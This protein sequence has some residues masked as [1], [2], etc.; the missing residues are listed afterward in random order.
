MRLQRLTLPLAVSG[1][2]AVGAWVHFLLQGL[3]PPQPV[4][5]ERPDY[6]V[7]DL[8]V[9]EMT[10]AG[11]PGRTLEA[12]TLRHYSQLGITRTDSPV[13]TLFENGS[14]YWHVRA[15]S[16][17]IRHSDEEILLEGEVRI[18]RPAVGDA[19]P[20]QVFTRDLRIRDQGA[21][22]ETP[23]EARLESPRH[24]VTGKGLQAWLEAPVR[25]KLL[26]QVR[27]HHELD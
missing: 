16:G 14:E 21:F 15:Q 12:T 8:R 9:T 3:A 5:P 2:V 23:H 13:L 24:K 22:A 7:G 4:D 25:V 19:E 17:R 26:A 6:V 20:L 11:V 1:I 18:D 10:P 27:G